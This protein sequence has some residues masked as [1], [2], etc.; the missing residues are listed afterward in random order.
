MAGILESFLSGA[1][2]SVGPAAQTAGRI[3]VMAKDAGVAGVQGVRAALG[4]AVAQLPAAAGG[5]GTLAAAGLA[6][7]LGSRAVTAGVNNLFGPGDAAVEKAQSELN[8][9]TWREHIPNWLDQAGRGLAIGAH[10]LVSGN[11][12]SDSL[13]SLG[14]PPAP[15]AAAQPLPSTVSPNAA[16]TIASTP[17]DSES[18]PASAA[19]TSFGTAAPNYTPQAATPVR[20]TEF[21]D[22]NTRG[23]TR[24]GATQPQVAQSVPQPT[25]NPA[26][27]QQQTELMNQ[28]NAAKSAVAAGDKNWGYKHGDITR[29]LALISALSPLVSSTNNLAGNM[30]GADAGMASHAMDNAAKIGITEANNQNELVKTRLA[31]DY[32]IYGKLLGA[33]ADIKLAERKAQLE[34]GTPAGVKAMLEA[35]G[36]E[37]D[38]NDTKDLTG[39]QRVLARQGKQVASQLVTDAAGTPIG[40]MVNGY[41]EGFSPAEMEQQAAAAAEAK[42]AVDKKKKG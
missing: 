3:G 39:T 25:M 9:G 29:N 40:R 12:I 36:L 14:E 11:S 24:A 23:V 15:A 7:D 32:G 31:G 35:M 28:I 2:S 22:F 10:A 34:A 37:R 13:Y 41:Y 16:K 20:Q 4:P 17:L 26:V 19:P 38:L 21:N 30:Y 42:A 27:M 5:L 18:A 8:K 33:E 1:K 6:T